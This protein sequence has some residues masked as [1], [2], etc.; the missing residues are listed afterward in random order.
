M[1]LGKPEAVCVFNDH[2]RCVRHVDANFDDRGRHKNI[3]FTARESAKRRVFV[4]LLHF[5][6]QKSHT[7]VGKDRLPERLRPAFGGF[8]VFQLGLL[9]RRADDVDLMTGI[10]L[11][12][13]EGIE[14][15]SL[16]FPDQE[17]FDRKSARRQLGDDRHVEVSVSNE[18]KRARN[19][20]GRHDQQVGGISL[21][22]ERRSL[23]DAEAVLLVADD[24]GKV[25]KLQLPREKCVRADDQLRRAGCNRRFCRA[26]LCGSHGAG[27]KRH[28]DAEGGEEPGK[29]LRVLLCKNFGRRHKSRL[30][31]VLYCA[32]AC[33]GCHHRFAAADVSLHEP[34]H[35]TAGRK[36]AQNIVNCRLL[37]VCQPEGKKSVKRLHMLRVHCLCMQRLALRADG[38]KPGGED[39]KFFEHQPPARFLQIVERRRKMD[40]LIGKAR[41]TEVIL[42][43]HRRGQN[44]R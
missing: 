22:R 18:R 28:M 11:L 9:H 31:P 40:R 20:R 13:D 24:E 2:E 26:L 29:R 15:L 38:G 1:E 27:Q 21:C 4:R 6:V 10:A 42:L 41:R 12:V 36:V 33:G 19:R 5:A 35:R 3:G 44:I 30:M 25:M 23:R 16:V 14:A 39:E 8:K 7:P 34:V 17:G 43:L 32:E 37:R